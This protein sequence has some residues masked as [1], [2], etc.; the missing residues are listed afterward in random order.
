MSVSFLAVVSLCLAMLAMLLAMLELRAKRLAEKAREVANRSATA[1][2]EQSQQIKA[3][4]NNMSQG[5]CMFNA[6]AEIVICN[7]IYLQMYELSPDVVK[8]GC[9]LR[10]LIEHRKETGLF[11]GDVDHYVASILAN[12]ASGE[13]RS[14]IGSTAD[15]RVINIVDRPM[16]DGG[17][18]VTH[19]DISERRRAEE[20]IAYMA[21]HDALTDLANRAQF[22]ERV[23]Y[24]L[25]RARRSTEGFAVF[26]IDV[27]YF[28]TVNDSLGHP[29]GDRL[30]RGVAERLRRATRASDTV[31]RLG[32]DEFA[33]LQTLENQ[34]IESVRALARRLLASASAPY[35]IDGHQVLTSVSI[36]VAMAPRDGEHASDLLKNADLA[37][38]RAKADGRNEYRIFETSMDTEARSRHALEVDLRHA[39]ERNEFEIFYQTVFSV[40]TGEIS[41]AEALLRW[42]HADRGM[43]RPD[44]FI[45]L[46]EESG[47]IVRI[48]AWV[49]RNA[50]AEAA[51]WPAPLKLSVNLSAVQFK[52][53]DLVKTVTG[54][55]AE[56]GLAPQRLELEIT[57][58]VLLA[59]TAD[60]LSVLHG[61]KTL[62]VNI[63]LDD[64]GAGFS[65]LS[66]LRMFPFDTIKID[67]TFVG[68]MLT[69]N[70]CAAIVSALTTLSRS[71]GIIT[72]AE[73]VETPEQLELLRAAGCTFAQGFMLSH[74]RPAAELDFSVPLIG[75]RAAS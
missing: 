51:K 10:R 39:L 26:V 52:R 14:H 68:D 47:Q 37:L 46:A 59:H 75:L 58:S 28:K 30:L 61:L 3:A 41:G 8:P 69:R 54:A 57:E 18:V 9:T 35:E 48:G 67:R 65:S 63:V 2:A 72:T 70:D 49:L 56:S 25:A 6:K 44:Q 32:G 29:V 36:G 22:S 71:L 74:P 45:P 19:E 24:E 23:E 34:S 43:V 33:I 55:L 66:Y 16:A 31:A 53:S 73:G 21:R 42:R 15:G 12:V 17:W 38:Y 20:K 62:G 27:D 13:T 64:F 5:L 40:E 11:G 60:T 1:L 50:C 4:L 7:D